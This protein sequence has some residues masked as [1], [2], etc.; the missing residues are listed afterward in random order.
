MITS[1]P[2]EQ[3]CPRT[4]AAPVRI[5]FGRCHFELLRHFAQL[6]PNTARKALAGGVV[7]YAAL[8]EASTIVRRI[9]GTES[10]YFEPDRY[11]T[12]VPFITDSWP[13]PHW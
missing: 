9:Q 8:W 12:E 6:V 1:Y 7:P 11:A 3:Q 13:Y 4:I 10:G 2:G 5:L